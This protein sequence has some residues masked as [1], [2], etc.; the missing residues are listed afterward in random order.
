MRTAQVL[1]ENENDDE[2][3]ITFTIYYVINFVSFPPSH[4][5]NSSKLDCTR[6]VVG[7]LFMYY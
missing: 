2:N 7:F 5:N 1:N 4:L 3:P 6:F